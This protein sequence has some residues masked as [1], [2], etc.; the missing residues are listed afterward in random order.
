MTSVLALH[1]SAEPE[2]ALQAAAKLL[3]PRGRLVL[4][5]EHPFRADVRARHDALSS[6]PL[7]LAALRA[8]G[9]RLVDAAEPVP[10]GAA[11]GEAPHHLVIAAERTSR[12]PR[13]RGTSR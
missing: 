9:L 10:P 6:L 5:L 7:L 11:K 12:R 2:R 13:N 8:A 4:A 1:E 3:H